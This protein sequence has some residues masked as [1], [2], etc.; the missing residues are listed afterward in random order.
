MSA[1][2]GR[3]SWRVQTFTGSIDVLFISHAHHF[4]ISSRLSRMAGQ[5]GLVKNH[6]GYE[7]GEDHGCSAITMIVLVDSEPVSICILRIW[8]WRS[9]LSW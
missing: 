3:E 5:V 1:G 2:S 7:W 8:T 4:C 6:G 9:N